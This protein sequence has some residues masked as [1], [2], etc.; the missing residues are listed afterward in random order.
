MGAGVGGTTGLSVGSGVG[1]DVGLG[2]GAN[3]LMTDTTEL[4]PTMM[5]RPEHAVAPWQPW[6]TV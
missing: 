1:G 6:V 3:P 5:E 2:V 4:M